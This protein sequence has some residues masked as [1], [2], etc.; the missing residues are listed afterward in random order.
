MIINS[1]GVRFYS[2]I[3]ITIDNDT[4]NNDVGFLQTVSRIANWAEMGQIERDRTMRILVKRNQSVASIRLYEFHA[5]LTHLRCVFQV[6]D[7]P[8]LQIK[9][10]PI[11][12]N[13]ASRRQT[14]LLNRPRLPVQYRSCADIFCPVIQE[15]G[16]DRLIKTRWRDGVTESLLRTHSIYI[17][18]RRRSLF[19]LDCHCRAMSRVHPRIRRFITSYSF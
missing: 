3:I 6:C 16:G 15:V 13:K 5:A 4:D 9:S 18:L 1:D 12:R 19:E 10:Q 11:R 2:L 8:L 17:I 7:L 14:N